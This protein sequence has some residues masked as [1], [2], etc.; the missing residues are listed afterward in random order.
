MEP[1]SYKDSK[2][3]EDSKTLEMLKSCLDYYYGNIL[4][5][6][7][8][9]KILYVNATLPKMY[10]ISMERALSMTA[11]DLVNEGVLDRSAVIEVL[12]TGREAVIKL[13]IQ[14]SGAAID[15]VAKPIYENGEIKYIIAFSH[16]EIF[17][18]E[19][20]N[21]LRIEKE[22]RREMKDTLLFIQQANNKYRSIIT[23]DAQ[24]KNLFDSMRYL[25]KTDSTIILYGES[26]VG[27][28][29]LANYIHSNSMR[30]G[31]IFLPVN[32]SAIP[33]E[34][35]ESEFFGYEKGS[36]T[37]ADKN[38][39]KGIFEMGNGGTVFLDEIGDLPPLMQAKLLRFL[40]SGEIK[41]V[42]STEIIYTNVRI[43]A[44]TN[45]DLVKM[46]RE[47]QFREDLYYRLNIIPAYIPPLRERPDDIEALAEHYLKEYNQKYG[48]SVKFSEDQ[49][50]RLLE[51]SWPGNIRELR[52]EVERYVITDGRTSIL[53]ASSLPKMMS[54]S[55][56]SG[57]KVCTDD[58]RSAKE[59]F[60]KDYIKQVLEENGWK[61]QKAADS[62]GIHRSVLYTKMEKYKLKDERS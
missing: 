28:D 22:K 45:R 24:M 10:N 44:A 33:S 59:R 55:K 17:M 51:Y 26:G 61:I 43:I 16:D 15:C 50:K 2:D 42:G 30:S 12:K 41:R 31:E 3:N 36:F 27:K 57:K 29:V 6:D 40:D 54:G 62:L 25:A 35:M 19:M 5:A 46:V 4:I 32:C 39:K 8:K 37:G 56:N 58:L 48:H 9:G 38:G 23:A 14:S 49:R 7:G 13:G 20:K 47:G 21:E 18:D 52:N 53:M 1:K 34:L 11:Y 60:E